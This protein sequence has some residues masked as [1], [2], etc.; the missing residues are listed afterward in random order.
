MS[1][2]G[3]STDTRTS[4]GT[5]T[6]VRPVAVAARWLPTVLG[7][8]LGGFAARILVGPA[9]TVA[10]ALLGGLV[11]GLVLGAV[12]AWGLDADRRAALR[13]TLATAAG[14]GVGLAAAGAAVGFG[15]TMTALVTQGA[16]CGLAVGAAQAAALRPHLG[17][18]ALAWPPALAVVWAA[19]W[20]VSTAIG[21]DVDQHFTVFGSSGA[22]VATAATTVLPLRL[23]R[24]RPVAG[25]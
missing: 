6:A 2:T 10:A 7:F 16:V 8:P 25:V 21:V 20:A 17:R 13:W 11:T 5:T 12:Q 24:L 23:R 1:S 14:L 9:D 19:G 18:A 3:T 15:T 22:V 4:T